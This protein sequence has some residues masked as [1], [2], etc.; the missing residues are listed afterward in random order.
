M[1][2]L[3]DLRS[4]V[5]ILHDA[6]DK[7]DQ[8]GLQLDVD[9]ATLKSIES[10]Q[11]GDTEKCLREMLAKWLTEACNCT[12]H[13]VIEALCSATV[14]KH[15]LADKLRGIDGC[16]LATSDRSCLSEI[17]K[18]E[19]SPNSSASEVSPKRLHTQAR[20]QFANYLE[21]IY[22]T[23]QLETDEKYNLSSVKSYINLVCM[24]KTISFAQDREFA[25]HAV[26]GNVEEFIS[27]QESSITLTDI[28]QKVGNRFCKLIL[29]E[30]APGIGKTTLSHE[31]CRQWSS[32]SLLSCY[33]IVLFIKLRDRNM[34]QASTFDC[35]LKCISE[36]CLAI[37]FESIR[38]EV[39]RDSGRGILFILEGLDE[40]QK[41]VR[42]DEN[43]VFMK[44]IRGRLLPA[45]TVMVTT[46]SWASAG[47]PADGKSRIDQHI[48]I[49]GF[50]KENI[51]SFID[52][53]IEEG[54]RQSVYD[55]VNSN[56]HV[57]SAMYNPLCAQIVLCVYR[58]YS[59]DRGHSIPHTMTEL[60]TS[61]T[62]IV[63]KGHS[64]LLAHCANIDLDIAN[65]PASM[66]THYDCIC[67]M[68][69]EGTMKQDQI[70]VFH[71]EKP[72]EFETLGL[73]RCV[74]PMYSSATKCQPSF[75]FVHFTLQEFMAAV[76]ISNHHTPEDIVKMFKTNYEHAMVFRFLAGLTKFENDVLR[77]ILPPPTITPR[78]RDV[79][80]HPEYIHLPSTKLFCNVFFT[81]QQ[82]SW[83]Y[84]SQNKLLFLPYKAQIVAFTTKCA[85]TPQEYFELGYCIAACGSAINLEVD[86]CVRYETLQMLVAGL[87]SVA[88]SC[89][90]HYLSICQ[91]NLIF[92]PLFPEK[93]KYLETLQSILIELCPDRVKLQQ[94]SP[95]YSDDTVWL[96]A[97][98]GSSLKEVSLPN[99]IHWNIPDLETLQKLALVFPR[100]D[101]EFDSNEPCYKFFLDGKKA[102]RKLVIKYVGPMCSINSDTWILDTSLFS[103]YEFNAEQVSCASVATFI[104][105]RSLDDVLLTALETLKLSFAEVFCEVMLFDREKMLLTLSKCNHIYLYQTETAVTEVKQSLQVQLDQ[106]E[107]TEAETP[108]F[109]WKNLTFYNHPFDDY[110]SLSCG[111][112][113]DIITF[114]PMQTIELGLNGGIR[115][116]D[117]ISFMEVLRG[118][119][120]I[121]KLTVYVDD[122]KDLTLDYQSYSSVIFTTENSSESECV[123]S[124][125]NDILHFCC[126][127][128]C[129]L[130]SKSSLAIAKMLSEN[131]TLQC[132]E[133]AY[134]TRDNGPRYVYPILDTLCH[135]TTLKILL[136]QKQDHS[137]QCCKPSTL[138]L[139]ED[140]TNSKIIS[141][142][143]MKNQTLEV[144]EVALYPGH[145]PVLLKGFHA[146]NALKELYLPREH[147]SDIVNCPEYMQNAQRIQFT[148]LFE[149]F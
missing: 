66:K 49:V 72:R 55:Y 70:L 43:S 96:P 105:N 125:F 127:P 59:Q 10:E 19:R 136:L 35:L 113:N 122:V 54:M 82:I 103:A 87:R 126:V 75:H 50:T 46:R 52:S 102:L 83:L 77:Y 47:I 16:G 92:N 22:N 4:L 7:W 84:E 51:F 129:H 40:L 95:K 71:V 1:L 118:N 17:R 128:A 117:V 120:S 148:N 109:N 26:H 78:S 39:T 142:L 57:L 145:Y 124:S 100:Q 42:E 3:D 21:D 14:G 13:R 131:K 37:Q 106:V 32:N 29:V 86:C 2:R 34:Q 104:E 144:L 132:L 64:S 97:V 15:E 76:H 110:V 53:V 58:E 91:H 33:R 135:N 94:A 65:L 36:D 141:N 28:A 114:F 138:S 56:P 107:L 24:K 38:N 45:C 74:Q 18:R 25:E 111:L 98:L 23:A 5:E 99:T 31:L 149:Y 140:S 80:H 79:I 41:T 27:T 90:L 63:L 6:R 8:F 30:G 101:W 81:P 139:E 134:V 146:N 48:E 147:A 61:Y 116:R 62:R 73:M 112:L 121:K 130:E 143:M 20:S 115:E 88:V 119:T 11:R 137:L 9:Y 123:F 85:K 108:C 67:K 12:I 93:A 44:L 89:Q 133:M 69:Y 60:Y 68:A